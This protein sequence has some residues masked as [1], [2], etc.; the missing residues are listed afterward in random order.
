MFSFV[1]NYII[2]SSTYAAPILELRAVAMRVLAVG[3]ALLTHLLLRL[4]MKVV[5]ELNNNN[6][7]GE[8]ILQY[9]EVEA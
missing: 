7:G 9:I 2:F 3:V 8:D 4:H 5:T 1:F 6:N